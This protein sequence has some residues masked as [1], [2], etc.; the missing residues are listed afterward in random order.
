MLMG[1]SSLTLVVAVIG[2]SVMVGG[3]STAVAPAAQTSQNATAC[4]LFE[5]GVN[6][7]TDALQLALTDG[8]LAKD[9]IIAAHDMLPSRIKDAEDKAEGDVAVAI[10]QARK[11]APIPGVFSMDDTDL[12]FVMSKQIVAEKCQAD[13][14]TIDIHKLE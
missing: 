11:L 6:Q 14:A 8:P 4:K 13:G 10:R 5:D 3:G 9:A 12:A 2:I 1:L 7:L